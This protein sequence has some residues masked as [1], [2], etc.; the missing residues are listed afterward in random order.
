MHLFFKSLKSSKETK[1]DF[2]TQHVKSVNNYSC[3]CYVFTS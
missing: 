3:R 1:K 2:L